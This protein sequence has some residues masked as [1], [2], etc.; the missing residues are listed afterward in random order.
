M[1]MISRLAPLLFALLIIQAHAA[2][3]QWELS[4]IIGPNM[5]LQ[6]ETE[7]PLWGWDTPGTAISV[8]FRGKVYHTTAA[9]DGSWRIRVTTGKAA[10][11]LELTIEGSQ[12][13]TFTNVLVGEVWIA[14]GQSNMWWHEGSCTNAEQEKADATYP[15]IRMWDA[16]SSTNS[17]GWPADTPQ[18]TVKTSWTEITPGNV[19]NLPGVPFFFARE[20]YKKLGVPVGIIHLAVPGQD[21]ETFA[22]PLFIRTHLPLAR[23]GAEQEHKPLPSCHFNGLVAPAAPFAARGF[24]WWQGEANAARHLQYASVFPGVIEDWREAWQLPAAPFLFVELANFL[25]PQSHPVEDDLWPALRAAQAS[26]LQ[27]DQVYEVTAVDAIGPGENPN[28]IHP[29]NKQLIGHRLYAAAMANVYGASHMAWSGPRF[30]S[31]AFSGSEVTLSFDYTDGGL[32]SRD[33]TALRGFAIAGPD[34]Q[35]HWAEVRISR[36]R[37]ILSSTNTPA[38]IAVRYS[39]AN[40]PIG[41]LINGKGLPA[42]PFRTDH[43]N[44]TQKAD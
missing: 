17:G 20:L 38:P 25:K 27:L 40:N 2:S 19:A 18:R 8:S 23:G 4:S 5:V 31:A 21:I 15:Q 42:F 26:A 1:N 16:N 14:G 3:S 7:A 30:K 24:L 35:F 43:W 10:G 29:P 12:K 32:A 11:P 34:R 22:S 41:N 39:W 37:V 6:R 9:K 28:N 44:L 36:N 33:G 13:V